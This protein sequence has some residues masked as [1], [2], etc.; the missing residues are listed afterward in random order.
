MQFNFSFAFLAAAVA[1][2]DCL[3]NELDGITTEAAWPSL[4]SVMLPS[5]AAAAA[6]APSR[7]LHPL[8]FGCKSRGDGGG[9]GCN[10]FGVGMMAAAAAAAGS[11][12]L[13]QQRGRK[14]NE[15]RRERTRR[16]QKTLRATSRT[17][18]K[19]VGR[20][21]AAAARCCAT[22]AATNSSWRAY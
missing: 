3:H 17:A 5:P 19:S 2:V 20:L 1:R 8:L 10:L 12:F 21:A 6:V 18:T 15:K 13:L 16:R 11:P 4:C 22:A 7:L 9:T 14:R